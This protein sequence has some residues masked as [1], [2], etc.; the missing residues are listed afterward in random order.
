MWR[1]RNPA[2]IFPTVKGT[3]LTPARSMAARIWRAFGSVL[4]YSYPVFFLGM[5]LHRAKRDE[6]RCRKKH[7]RDWERYLETVPYRFIPSV[8]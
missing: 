8:I 7:G 6:T 2:H 3:S 5:I 1:A 4:P